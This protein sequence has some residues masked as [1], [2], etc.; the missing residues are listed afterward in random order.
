MIAVGLASGLG[1]Y[2]R[3]RPKSVLTVPSRSAALLNKTR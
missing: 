1:V 3:M 2:Y